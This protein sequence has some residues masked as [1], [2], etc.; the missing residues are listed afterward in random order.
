MTDT[1]KEQVIENLIS[2]ATQIGQ[3]LQYC[4]E[5]WNNIR[6]NSKPDP[7]NILM[8]LENDDKCAVKLFV[9]R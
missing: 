6:S 4:K 1:N 2:N 9:V 8:E 5:Q 3:L 7:V